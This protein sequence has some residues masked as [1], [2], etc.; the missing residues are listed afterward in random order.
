MADQTAP[1]APVGL[2]HLIQWVQADYGLPMLNA[3]QLLS[4]AVVSPLANVVDPNYSAV[5]KMRKL[6]LPK[7][8][9]MGDTH[10]RLRH[11]AATYL[12]QHS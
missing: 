9:A 3:Y 6:W 5:A 11:R 1:T 4:Q 2:R 7:P 12:A 8:A 10:A